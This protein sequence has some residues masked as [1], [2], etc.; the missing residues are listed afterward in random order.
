MRKLRNE[1]PYVEEVMDMKESLYEQLTRMFEKWRVRFSL[2]DERNE[3][4]IVCRTIY[5]MEM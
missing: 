5:S 3:T 1:S 4:V 2:P